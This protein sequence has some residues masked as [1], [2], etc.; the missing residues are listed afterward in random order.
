[1]INLLG[2]TL[3]QFIDRP[4]VI[5]GLAFLAMGIALAFLARRIARAVRHQNTIASNDKAFLVPK[6]M[7]LSMV[8]LGFLL[9]AIDVI[10]V[11]A[12]A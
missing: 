12:A 10:I 2:K 4:V 1:M 7:G 9:V 5:I 3:D 6:I 8:V 11:F